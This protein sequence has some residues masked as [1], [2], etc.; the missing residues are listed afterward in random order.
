MRLWGGLSNCR[1]W[2]TIVAAGSTE[3]AELGTSARADPLDK[4]Q[5]FLTKEIDPRD[6][7]IPPRLVLYVHKVSNF[8]RRLPCPNLKIIVT[9][10]T[11]SVRR[12]Q[13]NEAKKLPPEAI[14]DGKGTTVAIR[15]VDRL[16][17]SIV[18]YRT[19]RLLAAAPCRQRVL[20]KFVAAL[21]QGESFR[22]PGA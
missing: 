18:T 9:D 13:E 3:V 10:P 7:S 5:V 14:S 11:R 20:R 17:C 12:Q 8:A 6:T 21:R 4:R 22:P 19:R 2:S 15:A 1:V 16:R